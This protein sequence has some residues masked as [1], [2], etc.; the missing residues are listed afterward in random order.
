MRKRRGRRDPRKEAFWGKV[1][2]EQVG[3]GLSVRG[4]C[5]RRRLSEAS[6]YAWRRELKRRRQEEDSSGGESSAPK[7]TFVPVT[8]ADGVAAAA[9]ELLLPSGAVLRLPAKTALSEVVSLVADLER[10]AC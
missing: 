5:R 6:F 2:R 3:S 4:F 7:Q 8:V 1:V 9:I 10:R